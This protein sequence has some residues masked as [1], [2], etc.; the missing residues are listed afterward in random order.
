[1]LG[2]PVSYTDSL[3]LQTTVIINNNFPGHVG[4]HVGS[5]SNQ[6]LYDPGGSYPGTEGTGNTASGAAAD[7][8][9][10]L[11]YQ[12]LDGPKVETHRFNTSKAQE[13]QIMDN[14]DSRGSCRPLY[15]AVCSSDVL[16]GIGPF[17]DLGRH[18]TPGG[19]G[20][21]LRGL[22]GRM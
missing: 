4:V 7:L 6:M 9:S 11:N 20:S 19:L 14:I 2:N 21:T 5:G 10:Y 22:P 15:C 12:R 16:R 13:Q 1:M 17:R 8:G 18:Y 3:G